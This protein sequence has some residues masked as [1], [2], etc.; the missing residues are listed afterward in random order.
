[1]PFN[2]NFEHIRIG[3]DTAG[4]EAMLVDGKTPEVPDAPA[5]GP[6]SVVA[7]HVN[8]LPASGLSQPE[9]GSGIIQPSASPEPLV[10]ENDGA[11]GQADWTATLV[12]P[13]AGVAGSYPKVGDWVTVIGLAVR[14]RDDPPIFYWAQT[15]QVEREPGSASSPAAG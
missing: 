7:I 3:P 10:V 8:W 9:H 13:Q 6:D 5:E 4:Q 14:N 12:K 11:A 2:S 1:M 15:L